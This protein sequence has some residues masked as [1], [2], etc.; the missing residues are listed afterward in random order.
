MTEARRRL[1]AVK[2]RF[3]RWLLSDVHLGPVKFGENSVTIDDLVTMDAQ[4]P[5]VAGQ[6]GMDVTSGRPVVFVDSDAK[7]AAHL[8]DVRKRA[9]VS[10]TSNVATPASAAPDVVDG[11][12]LVVGNRV[13]LANQ[14]A[15]ATNGLYIVDVLGTGADGQWT[16]AVDADHASDFSPG[17]EVYV[18]EGTVNS[19]SF[20]YLTT[21]ASITLGTTDLDFAQ[22]GVL[23]RSD[24]AGT[25]VIGSSGSPIT[26]PSTFSG[27]GVQSGFTDTR[28]YTD[29]VWFVTIDTVSTATRID[30]RV[31]WSEDAANL[32]QQGTENITNG[33]A[34]LNSYEAQYDISGLSAPFNLPPISL[35]VAAP[36]AK[37]SIKGNAG[38]PEGYVRVWRKA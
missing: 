3:V 10:S 21:T 9:R 26:I 28:D 32:G 23:V 16:R 8:S 34:E 33:T 17:M 19:Q 13:L 15:A 12:T 18:E 22:R 24:A 1:N 20:Y 29:A 30:V 37:V 36:N 11:V 25:D 38:S 27:V 14:M 4:V 2:Q 6:I 7:S 5:T 31:E 35:P